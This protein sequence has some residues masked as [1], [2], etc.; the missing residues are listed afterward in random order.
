M[1]K[2]KRNILKFTGLS[3]EVFEI[4]RY[5]LNMLL[6]RLNSRFNLL[7]IHRLKKF[8]N[9]PNIKLNIGAGPFGEDGWVN[10]DT[11]KHTKISFTYDCRKKIPFKTATV[12]K[13]RCEH[14][15]EHM[16]K[17]YE[18]PIFLAECKRVLKN[19]GILRIIV[20]DIEKYIKAYYENNWKIVGLD[21]DSMPEWQGAEVLSHIF[22]Q[23]GEH[24][25]GYDF[26]SISNLLYDVGF[27]KVLKSEFAKS[28][29]SDLKNDQ[30]NHQLYSL[31]VDA[32]K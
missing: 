31:Y 11:F 21:I 7:K 8:K 6:L 32:I 27:K 22:R 18:T 9:Q 20:P 1:K 5:E 29:D 26:H 23:G 16:D 28:F 13:I 2:S 10:I 19:D 25:F 24:K 14:F 12:H 4:F 17:I 30:H 3:N 15:L